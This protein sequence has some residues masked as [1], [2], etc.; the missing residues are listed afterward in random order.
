MDFGIPSPGA[1]ALG[2]NSIHASLGVSPIK[3]FLKPFKE[4][5]FYR[6]FTLSRFAFNRF[7]MFLSSKML[8]VCKIFVCIFYIYWELPR[9]WSLL[10]VEKWDIN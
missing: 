3:H 10:A 8:I 7:M 1:I 9:A 5:P 2:C 6:A 4:S